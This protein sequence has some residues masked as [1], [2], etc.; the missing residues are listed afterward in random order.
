MTYTIGVGFF[1]SNRYPFMIEEKAV[2]HYA[3]GGTWEGKDGLSYH[4]WKLTMGGSGTSGALLC[5][6]P[7]TGDSCCFVLGVHNYKPWCNVVTDLSSSDDATSI[8]S[9]FYGSGARNQGWVQVQEDKKTTSKGASVQ[10]RFT[11]ADG[12]S[13]AADIIIIS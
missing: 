6:N 11:I 7:M 13:L 2:W 1:Q 12:N 5:R 4:N 9:S 10:V 8:L 3:N